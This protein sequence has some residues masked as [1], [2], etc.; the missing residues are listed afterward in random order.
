[1]NTLQQITT[2]LVS[3]SRLP[4]S[5]NGNPRYKVETADGTYRTKPDA[6]HAYALSADMAPRPV[7]LTL[8][9]REQIVGVEL[10]Y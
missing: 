5:A 3:V 6:M 1:M 4:S 2:H 8:D 9:G 10:H 7:T